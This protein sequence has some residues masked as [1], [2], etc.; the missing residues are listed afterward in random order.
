[1]QL[2]FFYISRLMRCDT[3][4]IWNV[5]GS[6]CSLSSRWKPVVASRKPS[7][8]AQDG[9]DPFLW[10]QP[11]LRSP[12]VPCPEED[13]G[14]LSPHLCQISLP[15]SLKGSCFSLCACVPAALNNVKKNNKKRE[16]AKFLGQSTVVC[17]QKSVCTMCRCHR[18]C[19]REWEHTINSYYEV[20]KKAS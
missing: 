4:I 19:M 7:P 5:D 14:Y 8:A 17:R 16:I 13:M 15:M 20:M 1:M 12:A 6:S 10:Q 18:Y 11:C 9:C 2:L 3:L